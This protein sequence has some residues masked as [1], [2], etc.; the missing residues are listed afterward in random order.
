MENPLVVI[1]MSSGSQE[2]LMFVRLAI[3]FG[4][5]DRV[6]LKGEVGSGVGV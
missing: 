2:G 5:L 1:S 4:E 3:E 6:A